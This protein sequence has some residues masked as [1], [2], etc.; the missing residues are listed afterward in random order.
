[1]YDALRP[2]SHMSS[3][4]K[5]IKSGGKPRTRNGNTADGFS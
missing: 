5:N 3:E 1:M 2:S 4:R